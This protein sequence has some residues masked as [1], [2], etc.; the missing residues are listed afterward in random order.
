MTI[1]NTCNCADP[2]C[3]V[4]PT[5]SVCMNRWKRVLH[6]VDMDNARI[7]LCSSCADDAL[8]SGVFSESKT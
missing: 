7:E 5:H 3:P 8:E 2:E 1:T 4:H 6:R